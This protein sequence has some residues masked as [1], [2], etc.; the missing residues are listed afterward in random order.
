[1]KFTIFARVPQE[2][3]VAPV[4]FNVHD[5][6]SIHAGLTFQCDSM[7]SDL[8]I[9]RS[10]GDIGPRQRANLITEKLQ[11]A[12]DSIAN[13]FNKLHLVINNRPERRRRIFP[14]SGDV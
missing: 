10:L 2:R 9:C 11:A 12:A 1:M 7:N 13:C 8:K 4:L 6:P 3:I 14:S 5:L